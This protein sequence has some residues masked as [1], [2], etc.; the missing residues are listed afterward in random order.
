MLDPHIRKPLVDKIMSEDHSARVFHEFQL[1][2]GAGRADLAVV[3]GTM[4]G[5]EIKSEKDTT[6]RL[7]LQVE[8]YDRIFNYSTAVIAGKHIRN[9]RKVLPRRWGITVAYHCGDGIGFDQVR[10]PT[11]N[12]TDPHMQIRILWKTELVA[13]LRE[14]GCEAR[15]DE[16]VIR[17][18]D[19]AA[20]SMTRK[21]I[22]YAVR[23]ALKARST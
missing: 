10:K 23:A 15:H 4:A 7:S 18:W 13:A 9:A 6:D 22:S 19:M 21:Q 12:R 20:R 14:V 17:L 16:M 8:N 2:R 3:N 5:F 1:C 11:G